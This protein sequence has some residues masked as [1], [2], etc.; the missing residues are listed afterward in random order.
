MLLGLF[1][2]MVG[3]VSLRVIRKKKPRACNITYGKGV[4]KHLVR[5]GLFIE[6]GMVI[7]PSGK[8]QAQSKI[9]E[10]QFESW[11]TK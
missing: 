10:S 1:L 3:I 5:T 11:L 6:H 2:L 4:D 7:T 9:S 8:L